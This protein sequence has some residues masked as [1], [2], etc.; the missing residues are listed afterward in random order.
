VNPALLRHWGRDLQLW[1]YITL[2]LI[3]FR[4]LL[5]AIFFDHAAPAS[6]A[7]SILTVAAN[8]LRYDISTAATWVLPTFLLS[9]SALFSNR[10]GWLTKLRSLSA[11]LYVIFALLLFG[12]D[13]IFFYEYGDQ[14]ENHIFGLFHDD[15][16]AILITI[17]KEY[18]PLLFLAIATPLILFNL[19]LIHRWLTYTPPPMRV[20]LARLQ[21]RSVRI[22]AGLATFFFFAA[23]VRGG[24]LL[25]EPIRLKHAFVVDDMFLN[26]TVLNPLSAMRYTL[27]SRLELEGDSA[28]KHF[29]PNENLSEAVN[30]VR[31][32]RGEEDYTGKDLEEGLSLSVAPHA[33]H[34][35][36]HIFLLLMESHSGW[37]VMPTYRNLGFS[38]EFSKLADEGIYFPHFLPAANGTIGSLNALITGHPDSGL[39]L[40][41]EST[42]LEPYGSSIAT[43]MKQLGYK[44][45]FFYGGFLSWQRL[46][47]YARNQSFDEVYGGGNMSASA[48][49]NEWGV[50][51]EHLYQYV[52][53]TVADDTP[54]FNFILSTSNH[55]PYDLPLD[56]MGYHLK[57][58]PAPLKAT[59]QDSAKVLGHLWYAD[60]QAGHFVRTA[61]KKLEHALFAITGD[62]TARLMIRFP[63]D[64]VAEQYSVPFILFGPEVLGQTA[65]LP[66][67]GSHTDIPP[68]LISLAADEGFRFPAYGE[69][70]LHTR[71]DRTGFGWGHLV[72]SS[73]MANNAEGYGVN[74]LPGVALP[75]EHPELND[76]I[77]RSRALRALSWQRIKHGNSLSIK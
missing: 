50:D 33:G 37:T 34:K 54:S 61:E 69:D 27:Q 19:Y 52:L 45:R 65:T 35:P 31:H 15:T 66:T 75:S 2:T 26:R 21:T 53:D 25:G 63:G 3:L 39:N 28:L 68:T 11:S 49:T 38:P 77:K 46:D 5:I 22:V 56:E 64:S 6:G 18:H 36:K 55:P 40:N 14:F 10:D 51:D 70:M 47:S 30:F 29:W 62:H 41:H 59:K 72:G 16:R 76:D 9:L 48:T 17:W 71:D 67:A 7:A 42:A 8:G 43:I 4:L 1:G 60:K 12:A 44:T 23:M 73:F 32:Q 58:L 57:E 13:I 24:T 20:F 74:T